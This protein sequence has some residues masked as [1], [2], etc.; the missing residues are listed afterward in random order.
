[1]KLFAWVALVS[2]VAAENASESA[3]SLLSPRFK[4]TPSFNVKDY[5]AVGDGKKDDTVNIQKA[6][7]AWMSAGQGHLE[8]PSGK[9]RCG[10]INFHGLKDSTINFGGADLY[11]LDDRKK[12]KEYSDDKTWFR[13]EDCNNLE[14]TGGKFHGN[15]HAWPKLG[16]KNDDRPEMF[17]FHKMQNFKMHDAKL[18]DS[19]AGHIHIVGSSDVNVHDLIFDTDTQDNS[20]GLCLDDVERA[21]VVNVDIRNYDDCLKIVGKTSNVKFEHCSCHGGH[22]LSVGGGSKTLEAE[23]IIWSDI[24]LLGME[25]GARLKVT[26]DTKGFARDITWEKLRMVNVRTP[27]NIET[28]YGGGS[29]KHMKDFTFGDLYFSDIKATY[30]PKQ[31]LGSG[32]DHAADPHGT[33]AAGYLMCDDNAQCKKLHLTDVSI[34]TDVQWECDNAKAITSKN[35]SP[36]V[37]QHN[38]LGLGGSDL[39]VV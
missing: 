26:K 34:E 39:E 12:F 25:N 16:K 30:D 21:N 14:I 2:Q 7:D 31:D 9:Y 4:S 38:C 8:F 36:K 17:G 3:R 1:M 37:S 35:V 13:G 24:S 33:A 23:N 19:A 5:G 27:M 15:S 10:P 28:D 18:L 29:S 20:D 22:G 11:M 6:F 32:K